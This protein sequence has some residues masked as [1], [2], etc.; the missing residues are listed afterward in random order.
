MHMWM[1]SPNC[2]NTDFPSPRRLEKKITIF[3]DRTYGWQLDI[4]DKCIKG[5][6][7]S[8]GNLISRPIR[9]SG[10]AV[11]YIILS[12]FEMIAK[13]QDGFAH[14]G[15]S[16]SYFR[17]GVLSVFSMLTAHPADVVDDLLQVLYSGARCGLYHSGI[18]D[19]RIVLTGQPEVP[20]AF[21]R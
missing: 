1:I 18:T 19:R 3:L 17:E 7:D 6:A 5:E 9:D 14:N 15:K 13:F 20:M 2:K 12:Y 16:I 10:L 8:D 11:L 4:A 21:D